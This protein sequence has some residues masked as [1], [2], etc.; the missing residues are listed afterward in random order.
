MIGIMVLFNLRHNFT[1]WMALLNAV[2]DAIDNVIVTHSY[3]GM[4]VNVMPQLQCQWDKQGMEVVRVF[5][6]R[7]QNI[8]DWQ[9]R[10]LLPTFDVNGIWICS[11]HCHS[12]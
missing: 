7:G 4:V 11:F 3:A 12:E 9:M 2:T 8:D 10:L 6:E 5:G 1:S